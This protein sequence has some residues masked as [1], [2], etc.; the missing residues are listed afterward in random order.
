MQGHTKTYSDIVGAFWECRGIPGNRVGCMGIQG[1][2]LKGNTE[3]YREI[4][5]KK[6]Y[7]HKGN[8]IRQKQTDVK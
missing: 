6:G 2:K 3:K 7:A 8:E 1:S 4:H 5:D